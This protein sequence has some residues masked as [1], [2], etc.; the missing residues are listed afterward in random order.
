MPNK[1]TPKTIRQKWF[2]DI[3]KGV[4]DKYVF[5]SSDVNTLVEET[6]KLQDALA[7]EFICRAPTCNAKYIHHSR[8]V[9]YST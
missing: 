1:D 4:V 6:Q 9:R 8:R 7:A 5:G 3:C 2:L